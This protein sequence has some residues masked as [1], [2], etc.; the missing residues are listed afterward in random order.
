M[1][2][3]R[4]IKRHGY[5]IQGVADVLSS[6][7]GTSVTKGSLSHTINHGNPTIGYLQQIAD[8]IGASRAEF[9]EDELPP[10]KEDASALSLEGM[11]DSGIIKLDGKKYRQLFVP[12]EDNN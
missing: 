8:V 2:V 1:D 11:I 10:K 7:R 12:I 3:K 6:S 9:F 5:T 4:I